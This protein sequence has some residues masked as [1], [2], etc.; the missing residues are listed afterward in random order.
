MDS[1]LSMTRGDLIF[2]I[3]NSCHRPWSPRTWNAAI[4]IATAI[5]ASAPGSLAQSTSEAD[6]VRALATPRAI[7]ADSVSAASDSA[8]AAPAAPA[9]AVQSETA[10]PDFPRESAWGEFPAATDSTTALLETR[11]APTWQ[12]IVD[13]PYKVITFPFHL[14]GTGVEE[15][16]HFSERTGIA[17]VVKKIVS[18]RFLPPYTSLKV[19]GGGGGGFGGT[20]GIAYPKIPGQGK[21]VQLKLD[22]ATGGDRG[23]SMGVDLGTVRHGEVQF[24]SGYRLR[25]GVRFFG[26]GPESR[27]ED[28]SMFLDETGF[29]A[30]SFERALGAG[31]G[32]KATAHYSSIGARGTSRDDEPPLEEVF[33]G[34][35]P[36][37]FRDRSEGVTGSFQLEHDDAPE[38]TRPNRGGV[39]RGKIAYFSGKDDDVKFW[40]WR[41]E[42][43]QFVPLWF[44]RRSLALRGVLTKIEPEGDAPIPF[45]RLMTNDD[46]DLMRGYDDLRFRD[47]G[48]AL[49]TAEYRWPLWSLDQSTG[50]GID[51]FVFTDLGQVFSEL[52]DIDPDRFAESYGGGLR[53]GSRDGF[54]G[55]FEVGWSEDGPAIRLSATQP[56]QFDKDVFVRGRL[57]IPE[58]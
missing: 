9:A 36:F 39:R 33:A 40:T 45:Q 37:G 28:E 26:F 35:I 22:A 29:A 7:A 3:Q 25:S 4:L 48:L 20:F 49:I 5:G 47:L 34:S 24:A 6:S 57:F 43:Q 53:L 11:G 17:R 13:A 44:T 52:D 38:R 46:P 16:I 31:F 19:R 27:E 1:A 54:K 8:S 18:R 55:R 30:L 58:R 42:I 23:V 41:G 15:T 2:S 51:G 12:K 50:I 21:T 56:F 10:N 14:L 32:A